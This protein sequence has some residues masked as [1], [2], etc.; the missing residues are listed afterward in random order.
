MNATNADG[1]RMIELE[2]IITDREAPIELVHPFTDSDWSPRIKQVELSVQK[3]GWEIEHT[4]GGR[5]LITP[6]REGAEHTPQRLI[7]LKRHIEV[8]V[9]NDGDMKLNFQ[10]HD[11]VLN[12]EVRHAI[13]HPHEVQED[14]P[15][16]LM[17]Q[18]SDP[19]P[20][21]PVQIKPQV[22][23][24]I[25]HGKLSSLEVADLTYFELEGRMDATADE[26]KRFKELLWWL[27]G[28]RRRLD[29][30]KLVSGVREA[31]ALA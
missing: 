14:T 3:A 22:S 1:N 8:V 9:Q 2:L 20:D 28:N 17:P 18:S 13:R 31:G 16:S 5:F 19:L 7:D 4:G 11:D 30:D 10:V 29:F 21:K 12:K 27:E 6:G 25:A 23:S 24:E 26:R 15:I